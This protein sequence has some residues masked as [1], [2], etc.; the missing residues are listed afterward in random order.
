MPLLWFNQVM[1]W[2]LLGTAACPHMTYHC[3]N[4]GHRPQDIQSSRVNDGICGKYTSTSQS[5]CA[6]F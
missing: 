2:S 3:T 6:F 5:F 1:S 4:A